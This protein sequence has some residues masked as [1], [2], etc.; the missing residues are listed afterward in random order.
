MDA[1]AAQR[2]TRAFESQLVHVC[3]RGKAA[4]VEHM[5]TTAHPDERV[6]HAR[7]AVHR[8]ARPEAVGDDRRRLGAGEE[9]HERIEM[10]ARHF[11]ERRL[12]HMRQIERLMARLAIEEMD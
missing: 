3:L 1:A 11:V 2:A 12:V 6:Y 4:V 10:V 9:R 5:K 7:T 8:P